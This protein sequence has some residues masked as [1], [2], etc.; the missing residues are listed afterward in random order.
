MGRLGALQNMRQD[1]RGAEVQ[2]AQ[3]ACAQPRRGQGYLG[4]MVV[5][6]NVLE[7]RVEPVELIDKTQPSHRKMVAIFLI[8]PAATIMSSS[9]IPRQQLHWADD[10]TL[11]GRVQGSLSPELGL[12][13]IDQV[14]CPYGI[15]T[16]R[17]IRD[18][19]VKERGRGAGVSSRKIR[20]SG[21][22]YVD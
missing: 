3:R 4:R 11:T 19:L 16:A 10:T 17:K 1:L 5:F 15:K 18:E 2:R 14:P 7:H 9:R 20:A 12:Q 8:D 13:V 6:P 22:Q 21:I